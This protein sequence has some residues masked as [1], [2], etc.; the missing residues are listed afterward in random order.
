[1]R[2][3]IDEGKLLLFVP[4]MLVISATPGLCMTLAMT[5]GMTVG[6]ARTS[7]MML[8]EVSGVALV[9]VVCGVGISSLVA[10]YPLAFTLFKLVG[11]LYIAWLGFQLWRSRGALSVSLEHMNDRAAP[12]RG[13]LMTQ[14]FVTAIANP[15]GWAFFL[16]LLPPF[17]VSEAPPLNAHLAAIIAVVA[18]SELLCM[19]LY[20]LG[21]RALGRLLARRGNVALINRLAGSLMI[22]VAVWLVSS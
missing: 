4:T 9:V 21:G 19:T 18:A 11:A 2:A 15:K 12:A 13:A 7:W 16:A 22:A 8:G 6:L 5:L 3:M 17:L 10:A 14:G 1:M 20:A